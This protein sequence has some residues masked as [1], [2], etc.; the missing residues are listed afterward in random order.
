VLLAVP[1]PVNPRLFGLLMALLMVGLHSAQE[2][3]HTTPALSAVCL[4]ENGIGRVV[5]VFYRDP[6]KPLERGYSAQVQDAS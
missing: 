6:R 1:Q 3:C 2:P 5:P 4:R